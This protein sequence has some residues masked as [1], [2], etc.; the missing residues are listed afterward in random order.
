[1]RRFW[2]RDDELHRLE[3]ELRA[4][5]T[6]PPK[7]F[8]RTL[9][10][11]QRGEDR[12]LRP[13]VRVGLAIALAGLA[14]A[15][16]ASAGGFGVIAHTTKAAVKVMLRTTHRSP[17]QTVFSS[18]A[19]AQYQKHCGGPDTGK[20]HI[21]IYDASIKEG[22]TGITL[23]TFQLALD[24]VNDLPVTVNYSTSPGTATP[25][26]C[27]APGVDYTTQAGTV[28]FPAGTPSATIT[29]Q[30]CGDTIP[31]PNETFYIDLFA[32]SPNADIYRG[33]ATGT[34]IND[35]K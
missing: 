11:P 10:Q 27:P 3:A 35:D 30:V 2:T 28:V 33:R 22:N 8:I 23:L 29:I 24:A 17:R 13:K 14:L 1:V 34:I 5:R 9:V 21:T 12:W 20:C 19:N 18:P 31:E 4:N 25:G 32:P 15:A 6:E 26:A 7:G 16:M